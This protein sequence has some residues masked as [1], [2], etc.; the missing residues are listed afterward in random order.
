MKVKVFYLIIALA[1][2]FALVPAMAT[3][4]AT[5]V[6]AEGATLVVDDDG[7]ECPEAG[8]ET[9][10]AA[11]NAAASG[12]T[13]MVCPGTYY[14]HL[15]IS[16]S[17]T[18]KSS[19]GNWR[20]VDLD[21]PNGHGIEISGPGHVTV[22][23]LEIHNYS[24]DGI[25]I[26]NI[27]HGGSVTILDCFIHDNW[28]AGI[29]GDNLDG[30]LTIDGNI[31]SEN[32]F[33]ET[34]VSLGAVG[35]ETTGGTVVM[36]D[37]VIGA[38]Y[39]KVGPPPVLGVVD[40]DGGT[41]YSGNNG[42]GIDIDDIWPMSTVTIGPGNIIAQ[43]NGD[44]IGFDDIDGRASILGNVIGGWDFD[45]EGEFEPMPTPTVTP[46][47]QGEPLG[48]NGDLGRVWGNNGN[49]IYVN[50]VGANGTVLIQGNQIH[51]NNGDGIDIA[52]GDVY[53]SLSILNNII[54]AWTYYEGEN[55]QR[56]GGNFD[57]GISVWEMR[58]TMLIDGNRIAEND[59]I[60]SGIHIESID[61][62]PGSGS[63]TISNN[64]IGEW[65]DD[66]QVTYMGNGG[67]GI[68]VGEVDQGRTLMIGPN[69]N[70]VD[71][72]EMGIYLWD[73]HRAADVAIFDNT[74]LRNGTAWIG[75]ELR[76]CEDVTVDG[77]EISGHDYGIYMV[78]FSAFNAIINNTITDNGIGIFLSR[79][80]H[81]NGIVGNLIADNGHGIWVE[82]RQND[83]LSNVIIGNV[84]EMDSGVH[85]EGFMPG[86]GARDNVLN[87][88]NIVGN[89]DPNI[90]SYGVMN[91]VP[92]GPGA[93]QLD[94]RWNWWG[95][96]TGPYHG[97]TNPGGGGDSVSSFVVY[98]PWATSAFPYAYTTDPWAI[99][100]PF[101]TVAADIM[102]TVAMPDMISLYTAI[103]EWTRDWWLEPFFEF[104]EEFGFTPGPGDTNYLVET[105]DILEDGALPRGIRYV[106]LDLTGT[107]A[108]LIGVQDLMLVQPPEWVKPWNQEEW[109]EMWYMY[110][111]MVDYWESME[112]DKCCGVW[113]K[114]AFFEFTLA[115]L[116][117]MYFDFSAGY[118]KLFEMMEPGEL[119]VGV[120]VEDWA[121]NISR[122]T[123]D[124]ALVDVAI[125][126]EQG[127]N[128][129]S[130]PIDLGV[131]CW[132]DITD[133]GDG[134]EYSIAYRFDSENQKWEQLINTSVLN[135]LEG[136]AI[137]AT[138]RDA[139]GLVFNRNATPPPASEVNEGWNL[140]SLAVAPPYDPWMPVDN[141][142]ISVEEIA[143]D[144]TRG[145]IIAGSPQ[146]Y[147]DYHEQWIWCGEELED[148]HWYFGQEGWTYQHPGAERPQPAPNMSIGGAYW[149]FMER[150]DILAGFS[151]TPVFLKLLVEQG[152]D[153]P[154]VPRYPMTTMVFDMDWM[155]AWAAEC[156]GLAYAG[157]QWQAL[158]Y[159]GAFSAND[160]LTYYETLLPGYGWQMGSKFTVDI[161]ETLGPFYIGGA[162]G[163]GFWKEATHGGV[164]YYTDTVRIVAFEIEEIAFI[165]MFYAPVDVP[166]APGTNLILWESAWPSDMLYME[167]KGAIDIYDAVAFFTE[168]MAKLQWELDGGECDMGGCSLYFWKPWIAPWGEPLELWCDINIYWCPEFDITVI[169]VYRSSGGL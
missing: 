63:V 126:L 104:E 83:I 143:P 40:G 84:A 15:Y 93:E 66:H 46:T 154:S 149:L 32:G 56:F 22:Q 39:D 111:S 148:Y 44:G 31:I 12:D 6:A 65:T 150:D 29:W 34:G 73:A 4:V 19:T 80:T 49:G 153:V 20:D 21:K 89:S 127:W 53:G 18:L 75:I 102:T 103:E 82:G 142:L 159:K 25:H 85:F 139:L 132:G 28:G 7:V 107:V 35:G 42:N 47:L 117:W 27:Q 95:D 37:N 157:L 164:P 51:E 41:Y 78:N 112:F 134:L 17:L 130:T 2:M 113:Y 57:D 110:V 109:L 54:G 168:A 16:K 94:A 137:K 3:S 140:V 155:D 58:G 147:V 81:H 26:S 133:L 145:Y 138:S 33:G 64:D 61:S 77:N 55:S 62:M 146:Q 129:R 67:M 163:I 5:P 38:W 135:P 91:H 87:L 92:A 101:D 68:Y 100:I 13:V 45:L 108:D 23:G 88:N 59:A 71:N 116:Y 1:L 72:W 70:I 97:G 69:N 165:A 79:N 158:V 128:L 161:G 99:L 141:A 118:S 50:D 156:I 106:T 76:G 36:T 43:N 119:H 125:P 96:V 86:G 124:I 90:G 10:Q 11:I 123:I 131:N 120:T 98:E 105:T 74:I 115:Y 52:G 24:G 14:E 136:I 30:L 169:E 122:G 152:Q 160:V 60:F 121:G 114:D 167:Y 162:S 9:I 144:G 151:S 8:Y 166:T 48:K